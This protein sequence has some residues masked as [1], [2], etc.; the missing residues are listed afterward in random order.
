MEG[1][2]Q[3]Q[4]HTKIRKSKGHTVDLQMWDGRQLDVTHE[5]GKIS[6]L[7]LRTN[8]VWVLGIADPVTAAWE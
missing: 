1:R 6:L 2:L 3:A 7:T 5:H 8:I 4:T